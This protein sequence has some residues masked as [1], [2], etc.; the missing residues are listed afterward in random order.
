MPQKGNRN[1]NFQGYAEAG[2]AK[3]RLESIQNSTA[4]ADVYRVAGAEWLD[5]VEEEYSGAA[6]I[7]VLLE[8]EV[9]TPREPLT[10][11]ARLGIKAL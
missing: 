11:L 6:D 10:L 5:L 2:Q 7:D 4:R 1:P 3:A 9:Y 8:Q